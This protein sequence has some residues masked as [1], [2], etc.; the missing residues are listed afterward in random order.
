MIHPALPESP[1][2]LPAP[3]KRGGGRAIPLKGQDLRPAY[4]PATE[5]SEAVYVEDAAPGVRELAA[6]LAREAK[7]ISATA[8]Q[9][10]VRFR[11][12]LLARVDAG[13]LSVYQVQ[14]RLTEAR[15]WLRRL[16]DAGALDRERLS[17]ALQ[18]KGTD[19]APEIRSSRAFER[20]TGGIAASYKRG[21]QALLLHLSAGERPL[22]E[23]TRDDFASFRE[24]TRGRVRD[25][26]I[27][28]PLA[29]M[30]LAG[31]RLLIQEKV[32]LG[33]VRPD[34][35]SAPA[36]LPAPA[37]PASLSLFSARL[38]D[39]MAASG[40]ARNTRVHYRRSIRHF[41]AFLACEGI[42]DLPAV[43]R[44]LVT[45]YQLALQREES[46][47]GV[48]YAVSTQV[49][50]L[51]ALRFL[52]AHLLDAGFLLTDPTVHLTYPRAPRR[53]PRPLGVAQ[54]A[55]LIRSLP[56]TPLG[57]RDRAI[58]ELLYGSGL[59]GGELCCLT[60][61]DLDFEASLAVIR[62][63]KGRKDRVVPMT[64]AAR[65][66]LLDYLDAVRPELLKDGRQA[67]FIG[68]FG[69]ALTPRQMR[70]RLAELGARHGV[71]LHPHLLRHTC[72]THLLKGRADIRHIQ[73]LLGHERLSTTERYTRVEVSDLRAVVR[74]CH[75]R[76]RGG[77]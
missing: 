6:F 15:R 48:P 7:P 67:L 54:V 35:L 53:L 52:F 25:G 69:T 61:Q 71:S 38:E 29:R 64:R 23:M 57:I 70:R 74:R 33:L 66:A 75:P 47:Q 9:D 77:A 59:R 12:E 76:E 39:A 51:A 49:G 28:A 45:G 41:L 27:G 44:E 50:M 22:S 36:A 20:L 2:P 31:A 26:E 13:V 14:T 17:L 58:L 56:R 18:R 72:A 43:T 5:T 46:K 68:R 60:L 8:P 30:W 16:V 65:K 19:Y 40:L 62:Q 11:A 55:R 34:V 63:G 21:A 1:K 10:L 3:A 32:T 73:R 37:L 4:Q 42:A 24:R